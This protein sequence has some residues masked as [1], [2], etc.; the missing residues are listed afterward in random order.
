MAEHFKVKKIT[1]LDKIDDKTI[2]PT[3][4]F[5]TITPEGK[6]VQL[7]FVEEEEQKIEPFKVHPGIWAITKTIAGLKLT[8]TSFT[9]DDILESF[10]HTKDVTEKINCF[11]NRIDVYKK[12]QPKETPMRRMILFG[13]AGTGKS[14]IIAKS[15]RIYGH[16]KKTAIVLWYTD[17]FEAA[18]IKN[19]IKSFEYVGVERMILVVED[20]GGVEQNNSPRASES[21][22]LSLLD[23]KEVTFKVPTMII[24]TTNH[25]E[26][27]L[28][29]IMNRP[30]RFPDKIRV[31]FPKADERVAL[32]KH[33]DKS[34]KTSTELEDLIHSEQCKTFTVDHLKEIFL[35]AELYD[36]T[37][38]EV[39]KEL[40][41]KLKILI[42]L[43][44]EKETPWE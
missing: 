16:D 17:Q 5:A 18:T 14:T 41:Q 3:S 33:F 31:D 29:N 4:D 13:P 24:A 36:K 27:F 8:Q 39:T 21:S 26:M 28:G 43:S 44:L 10:S 9:E 6:F 2:F 19:F 11:F 37:V 38:L 34:K 40:I 15:S 12:L 23:N 32:L 25:P 1:D 35:R 42:M 20:I 30:G 7:E 22:L